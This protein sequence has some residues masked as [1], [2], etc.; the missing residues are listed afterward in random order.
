M[1]RLIASVGL[2][3]AL[4]VPP[5]LSAVAA[6]PSVT[7]A[8]PL[9]GP[10]ARDEARHAHD[11]LRLSPATTSPNPLPPPRPS[12]ASGGGRFASGGRVAAA[13]GAVINPAGGVD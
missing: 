10:N 11:T 3:A 1:R 8:D 13:N 7:H 6:S 2:V 12:P 4:L 9:M 5:P